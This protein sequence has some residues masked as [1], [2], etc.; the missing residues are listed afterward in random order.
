MDRIL[1]VCHGNICRSPYAAVV[2]ARALEQKGLR[3]E[4]S[5]GGLYGPD[6]PAHEKA[7]VTAL[8]RGVD[9]AGHRS[10]LVTLDAARS[11]DLVIVME[12]R[13]A[14]RVNRELSVP[15]ARVLVLGDLDPQEVTSR[16]IPDPYGQSEEVFHVT[17]GRIDRCVTVLADALAEPGP[18]ERRE[19]A[20]SAAPAR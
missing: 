9:L 3:A 1:V 11:A 4:V 20:A 10:R 7:R 16:G 2:L 8:A 17:Y 18:S 14:I 5:Q 13:Q 19:S 12:P 15:F 6:R